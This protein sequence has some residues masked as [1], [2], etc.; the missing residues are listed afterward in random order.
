MALALNLPL[1]SFKI[2]NKIMVFPGLSQGQEILGC[3]V[4][5]SFCKLMW[6]PIQEIDCWHNQ[7][8]FYFHKIPVN[9]ILNRQWPRIFFLSSQLGKTVHLDRIK[10]LLLYSIKIFISRLAYN[11]L[12]T[13]SEKK[14]FQSPKNDNYWHQKFRVRNHFKV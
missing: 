6:W 2:S 9:V 14:Y 10:L 8:K 3:I 4:S 7:F 12:F 13:Y 5:P 1:S 11:N